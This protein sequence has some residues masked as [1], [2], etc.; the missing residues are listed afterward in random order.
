MG[1]NEKGKEF[2]GNYIRR[3]KEVEKEENKEFINEYN[4]DLRVFNYNC[5]I[6]YLELEEKGIIILYVL[7][8][9]IESEV[10]DIDMNKGELKERILNYLVEVVGEIK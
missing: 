5:D 10:L 6:I 2:M 8:M 1:M 4:K 3:M 9:E 7:K